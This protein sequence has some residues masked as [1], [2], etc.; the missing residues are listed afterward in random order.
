M[1]G[2]WATCK[3]TSWIAYHSDVA[4]RG[5]GA[6]GGGAVASVGGHCQFRKARQNELSGEFAVVIA[7]ADD[8]E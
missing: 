1:R 6:G 7:D 3:L 5:G 4:S 2:T 8:A